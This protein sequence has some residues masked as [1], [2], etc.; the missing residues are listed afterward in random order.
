MEIASKK[1]YVTLP[2]LGTGA[3]LGPVLHGDTLFC[4]SLS[5]SVSEGC[6]VQL[7]LTICGFLLHIP[8]IL[9]HLI[10]AAD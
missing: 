8:Y 9:M 1:M 10:R 6:D 4:L 5:F 2:D 7:F 3:E